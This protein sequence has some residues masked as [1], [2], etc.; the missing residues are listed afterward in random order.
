MENC[1]AIFGS[2]RTLG[3]EAIFVGYR[4]RKVD[5]AVKRSNVIITRPP[6]NRITFTFT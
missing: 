2:N 3:H 6:A 1:S 4:H 5:C